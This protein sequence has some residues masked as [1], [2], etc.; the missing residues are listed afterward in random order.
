MIRDTLYAQ[1]IKERQG[2]SILENENGFIIY[3]LTEQECF[4]Q[5]MFVQKEYRRAGVGK[6]LLNR[7]KDIACGCDVILANIW[8]WDP[9]CNITLAGALA[10]G[11][12]VNRMNDG[13]IQII[14]DLEK[15]K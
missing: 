2:L 5:D 15:G 4:I 13:F 8:L 3:K 1:Y 10:C 9:N 7:L 11:F 6:D 12:R 14:L